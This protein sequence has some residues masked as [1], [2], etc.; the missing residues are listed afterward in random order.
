MK[1]TLAQVMGLTQ[2]QLE[3]KIAATNQR[4]MNRL[5]PQK[6]APTHLRKARANN[7]GL[8]DSYQASRL[9]SK[10]MRQAQCETTWRDHYANPYRSDL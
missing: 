4:A 6:Q 3:A 2:E 7:P 8:P 5:A 1:T 9:H 10:L